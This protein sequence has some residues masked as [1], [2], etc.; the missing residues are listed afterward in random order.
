MYG[1]WRK[2]GVRRIPSPAC[3]VDEEE[4]LLALGD[5]EH[6][7]DARIAFARDEPLLAV[8]HPLVAVANRRRLETGEVRT[9]AGSVSAHASR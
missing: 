5:C 3:R 8:Q 2:D 1:S 9:G 6:D 7:V 4:R